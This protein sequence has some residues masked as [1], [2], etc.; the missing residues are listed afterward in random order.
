MDYSKPGDR[1]LSVLGMGDLTHAERTVLSV[2]AWHD[3]RGGCWPSLERIAELA[4]MKRSTA[5]GHLGTLRNKGRLSWR[6][7]RHT[8]LYEIRYELG[9]C[10]EIPDGENQGHCQEF[11]T[12]HCQEFPD[13]NGKEPE[14]LP[15]KTCT[16]GATCGFR[17]KPNADRCIVCGFEDAW[18]F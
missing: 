15:R 3:G 18:P 7:G 13:G 16:M 1:M 12:G 17:M 4:V 8:N 11:P 9:H 5:V 2:L 14:A 6:H 10:Q